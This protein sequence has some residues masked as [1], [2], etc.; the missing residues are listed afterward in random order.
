MTID[1]V[2]VVGFSTV[3]TN[4]RLFSFNYCVWAYDIIYKTSEELI[5]PSVMAKTLYVETRYCLPNLFAL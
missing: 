2:E 5:E 1:E 3:D 4:V